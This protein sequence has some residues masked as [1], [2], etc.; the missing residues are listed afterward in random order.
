M[1]YVCATTLYWTAEQERTVSKS[2]LLGWF[3]NSFKIF[4]FYIPLNK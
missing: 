1:N 2:G 3:R 4:Q